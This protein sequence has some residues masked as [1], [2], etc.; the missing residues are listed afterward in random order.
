MNEV[1]ADENHVETD[2]INNGLRS[3]G[4]FTSSVTFGFVYRLVV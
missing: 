1:H 4:H 3:I 2:V